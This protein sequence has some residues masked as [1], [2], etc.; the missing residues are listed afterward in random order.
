[1]H[2]IAYHRSA[3]VYPRRLPD[4]EIV[5]G[6]PPGLPPSTSGAGG[7]LQLLIPILGASGSMVFY[8]VSP[9]RSPL[10][11][12]ATG[13]VLVASVAGGILMRVQQGRAGKRQITAN[14]AK[15]SAYLDHVH[16]QLENITQQQRQH[17]ER[18]YPAPQ[19]LAA[20]VS[21]RDFLWERRPTDTDFLEVRVGTGAAPLCCP[22]RLETSAL[23]DYDSETLPRAQALLARYAHIEDLPIV[24]PLRSAGSVAISGRRPLVRALTRAMVLQ[25]AADH[26]PDDVRLITYFPPDATDEWSWMK[27]LPHTRRLRQARVDKPE[28]GDPLCLMAS[29]IEDFQSLLA[30]QVVPELERRRKL[31]SEAPRSTASALTPHFVFIL[32]GFAPGSSLARI[33]AVDELFRDA[34]TLGATVI[35]L[36]DSPADEPSSLQAR[37]QISDAGWLSYEESVFGGR[38]LEAIHPDQ[39]DLA[40]CE[41]IARDL[42]PLT[43]SEKGAQHDLAQDV[44]LLDL[45]GI[46]SADDV[47]TSATWRPRSREEVLRVPIGVCADGEPLILDLKEAAEGGMGVHG[48]VIGATGSG[49]SE[50]LRTIVTS[51]AITHDPETINFVLAD[52]KGGAAFADLAALPHAAGMISNLQSDL[53]LVDRMRAALTGEQERRQRMLREAGNLDNIRQYHLKR[54]VYP[55]M[56]PMPHLLIIV[57]EFAELLASR[58]DFLDLFVAIGR[59]GRSLGMHLLLATQRLSEGRIQ[60]LE[61][62]L[63]YR[64]CLRTFSASESS[65]VIGT[66]DAFYLP[67]FPGIGYFKVDT[68]IYRQFKTALVSNPYV[69]ASAATTAGAALTLREFTPTGRLVTW[70]PPSSTPGSAAGAHPPAEGDELKTDMDVIITR[71]EDPRPPAERSSVHQVWLPPLAA[72]IPLGDLMAASGFGALDGSRWASSPPFGSLVIPVGLLDQ[73]LEQS[74]QPLLLDFSG[75]GGHLAL[76]GAPQSGKST[77]LQTII[78][79]FALTHTPRDVQFYCLDLGGGLLRALESAPHVGAVC[80]KTERDKVRRLVRQMRTIIEEREFLFHERR[81]DGMTAF[82]AR[83]QAGDLEDVAFGDVFLIVDDLAQL[84]S[85][86]DGIEAELVE[87]VASGLTYGVHVI[88]A[89]N[90]WVDIRPKLRDNIG[91]RIELR[92]N[93]PIESEIGKAA[94]L[95]LPAG[96]PGRGLIKGGLQFQAALPRV[97][98]YDTQ[99]EP[100][101]QQSVQALVERMRAAWAGRPA[102]PVRMLPGMVTPA[103]LPAAGSDPQP[104]VPIGLEEFQLDPVY[105]DL[106]AAGPHFLIF[107]DGECGKTTLLRAWMRAL[108]QRSTPEQAQFALVDYRRNLV[109]FLGS[110]LMLDHAYA[111]TPSMV[112]DVVERLKGA[113]EARM[114]PDTITLEDLRSP[115]TWSGP[116]YYLFVDDY[117]AIVPPSGSPLAPLADLMQQGRDVGFHVVLA[118]R[119]AGTSRTAFEAVFQRLKESGSPGLVMSGDPQE[120]P[121][122]GTQRAAVLPSG[123]GYLVRR[124]QRPMLVQTVFVEP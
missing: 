67:S 40:L 59:V 99:P 12:A 30:S 1:M 38:R 7:W 49:K 61:G 109:D 37:L 19:A 39:A 34:A 87:I 81:I 43:L 36:V 93:D 51:L 94:A 32:D 72:Q 88:V 50:L 27:W 13:L 108:E 111:V 83:R 119:V 74:Q 121:L 86:F 104:G 26:A 92:L 31:G 28:H 105:I 97:D 69:P 18:L 117:D 65:S 23:A 118:R 3:R 96:V 63:R 58:P 75:A 6:A 47:S 106:T 78:A 115:R 95:T 82:R 10:V 56:E 25:M 42:T 84:L 60:G 55:A 90:R 98:G 68:N 101:T 44:R 103:D 89:S 48:L 123:R 85:E 17:G 62:H 16:T 45:L 116:H 9:V 79:A 11:I 5:I 100:S 114:L 77:L 53:T 102:P 70:V 71:L 29:S 73:P 122:L 124:N 24:V 14:R 110:P 113:L 35:C 80:G 66:P 120:G 15:Y 20:T 33:P 8:L 4:Q 54:Q 52:F 57:D 76:A 21:R 46:P 22:L 2:G 64:I 41:R 107:G 91:T 112:K